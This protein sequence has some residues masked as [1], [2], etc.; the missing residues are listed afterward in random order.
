MRNVLNFIIKY[1]SW[2]VFLVYLTISLLL[3][4]NFNGFQQSVYFSSANKVSSGLYAM[5]NNVTGYFGLRDVAARLEQENSE[6]QKHVFELESEIKSLKASVID[7]EYKYLPNDRYSF[8]LS[9]VLNNDVSRRQNYFTIDKG[10][11]EGVKPGL[12]VINR[13]GIVGIVDIVGSHTSRVISVLNE[14]QMFSVKL[15]GTDYSGSLKW[16]QGNPSIAYVDEM[17]R[18]MRYRIGDTIVTS[19]FS[20]SFPAGLPVGV[21]MGR[22]HGDNDNNINLKIRLFPDFNKLESVRIIDHYL[23]EEIDSLQPL[24]E[25]EKDN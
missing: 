22:I 14:K 11:A 7:P 6:L 5:R 9:I 12:G 17:P 13:S 10:R 25:P 23:K 15:K 20:T 16:K 24:P 4:F 3:L 19:G 18:H 1:Q 2:L 8:I 21:V